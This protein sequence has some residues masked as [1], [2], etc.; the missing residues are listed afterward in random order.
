MLTQY[1]GKCMHP[2]RT[3]VNLW[4]LLMLFITRLLLFFL[5][6]HSIVAGLEAMGARRLLCGEHTLM[7]KLEGRVNKHLLMIQG[8]FKARLQG[9]FFA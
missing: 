5:N 6:Y 8:N 3:V 1:C 4:S 2:Y 9:A 7:R